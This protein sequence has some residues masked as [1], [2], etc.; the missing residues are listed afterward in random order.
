MIARQNKNNI[1]RRA[2]VLAAHGSQAH[3]TINQRIIA[4][5]TRL[6]SSNAFGRVSAAFHQGE[7]VFSIVL[8]ELSAE[9]VIVVPVMTS[10]GYYSNVVLPRELARNAC[11]DRIRLQIT[12]PIGTHPAMRELVARRTMDLLATHQLAPDQTTLAIVGHGAPRHPLSRQSTEDLAHDLRGRALCAH[13]LTAFLDEQPSVESLPARTA[14]ENLVVI[15]FLIIAGPHALQDLSARLGINGGTAVYTDIVGHLREDGIQS[16]HAAI[17]NLNIIC[18][19]PIGIDPG[20]ED[21]IA[22]IAS[23]S[24]EGDDPGSTRGHRMPDTPRNDAPPVVPMNRTRAKSTPD[25]QESNPHSLLNMARSHVRRG[26]V[27]LIGAGPGD[28]ELI[29]LRGLILLRQ[30]DVVLH[31][32]LI[33]A[34]LLN[35]TRP[36]AELINVGKAPGKHRYTQEAINRLMIDRAQRGL[37][38]V[39]LKG[40]DPFVFAHGAEEM[41]ACRMEGLPCMVVPGVSSAIAAPAAAGIPVTRRHVSRSFAV[42]TARTEEQESIPPF[43]YAGLATLDTLVILM[44]RSNLA[45]LCAA[46]IAGGRASSTPAACIQSATTPAQRVTRATLG[47]IAA[48]ADRDGIGTPVVTI[49]GQVAAAQEAELFGWAEACA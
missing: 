17:G 24:G 46:L 6:E 29:T 4:L 13:V 33:P 22:R 38:V 5:A 8:D 36:G 28:P 10:R 14:N 19:Q 21:V 15:P 9:H 26:A 3:P 48:A 20:L 39:R 41:R 18:D 34:E 1:A 35:E 49:I 40:G 32:R 47:T 42:V 45:E 23:H 31:D 25:G 44:G 37:T 7:P 16:R 12:E 27:Y 2:L 43:D 11:H 30:A